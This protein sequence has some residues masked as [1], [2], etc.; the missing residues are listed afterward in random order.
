MLATEP[1]AAGSGFW[2]PGLGTPRLF[3]SSGLPTLNSMI[4]NF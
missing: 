1:G 4:F 2:Y 3:P